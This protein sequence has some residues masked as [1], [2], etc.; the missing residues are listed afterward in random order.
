[1]AQAV[2][3]RRAALIACSGCNRLYEAAQIASIEGGVRCGHCHKP[4][5]SRKPNSLQR[6]WGWLL[7]A[8]VLYL[9]AN[10]YPMMQT[11]SL[12]RSD[13]ASII[14]GVAILWQHGSY[15]VAGVVFLASVAIPLL[16]FMVLGYLLLSIQLHAQVSARQRLRLH[17]LVEF[18]GRWSMLDV[19]VVAI[20]TTL[21]QFQPLA[22][23]VPGLGLELF[24]AVVVLTMVA[25]NSIDSRLLWDSMNQTEVNRG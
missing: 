25:A 24:A 9:P 12:G 13:E 20:L 11:T 3:A 21:V 23:V 17:R 5:Y 2:T 19:F 10:L 4:L 7:A 15:L 18:I 6:A 8:M 16:K 1:M 14:E 22:A